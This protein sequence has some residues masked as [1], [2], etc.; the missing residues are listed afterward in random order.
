MDI[1]GTIGVFVGIAIIILLSAKG[2]HITIAA[3]VA[4]LVI[5]VM[6]GMDIM[7]G[8]LGGEANNFMGSLGNYVMNYFAIFLL[9][10]ILAKLME[11]S[12]A[13]VS[14]ADTILNKIGSENP[15]LVM[16]AI[17]IIS[18][19]L[20]YGGI[21]L[22]VS[23][24][25]VIP[26]ARP[27]FKK[28]D[29]SWHLIQ[30]PVW[31]GI[32]TI[33]MTMLPGT[34]AIQNVIPMQYLGTTLTAAA[35]PS[36]LASIGAVIFGLTYMK[37]TLN[38]SIAK[39][40]TYATYITEEPEEIENQKLPAFGASIIPLL[41]VVFMAI[42]GSIF[43]NEYIQQN[44]IYF[45]LLVGIFLSIA[46][47]YNFIPEMSK[48]LSEGGSGAIGPIFATSLAVA[49]GAVVM[50]A[51]GFQ[52]ISDAILKMPGG[53]LIS[54]TVLTALMSG[55]TGSSS[56]ALGI[57]MP[58]Y[59]EHYLAAGLAPELI[60][61]VAAIGSNILTVPPHGGAMITF[62]SIAGLNHKNGFK[63]GFFIVTG[64]AIVAQTIMIIVGSIMY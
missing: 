32:A 50:G 5:L 47:F 17:F 54:L 21:S 35:I 15:Y 58:T 46:L 63:E 4:T 10:S 53:P 26:L 20:T 36:I 37:I 59:A 1:F 45:A 6:N 14:I 16:V 11:K 57:V 3:P 33:S 23:M 38:R 7:Q 56:G 25:A 29:I 62:L 49:F 27:L 61:R 28:L 43:G 31:L 9:G 40:D 48:V 18:V 64:S 8:M 13:T 19:I 24:F 2:I 34:P 55:I 12:G 39:G 41:V 51:P 30:L 44:I 52:A 22:F 60:H 42:S